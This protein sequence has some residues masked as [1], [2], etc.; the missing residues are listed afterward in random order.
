MIAQLAEACDG[1]IARLL[2]EEKLNSLNIHA[3]ISGLPPVNEVFVPIMQLA[4][5]LQKSKSQAKAKKVTPANIKKT[6]KAPVIDG[7]A[8]G[9]WSEA[10][11]YGISNQIYSPVSSPNDLSANY[12]VLWDKENLYLLVDVIDDELVND[13]E[14]FFYDDT[15]EVFID[16]DNSR[17]GGYGEND[18]TYNICWDGTSPSF[19]ERGQAYQNDDIKYALVTT[20][21]GYRL[22]MKFPWSALGAKPSPGAKIGLDVHVNDDDDGGERDTKFTWSDTQD[23]AF[24]NTRVFGTA[25]LAGLVGWWKFDESQGG[26]VSDSSGNNN[27][28]SLVGDPKWQPSG[29]ILGGALEFDGDGDYVKIENESN[30]D[31]AGQITVATWVNVASV[32]T[33]WTAIVTKGD[34]A[35]RLSTER[36]E[37][38]FH[39]AV[40]GN[41]LI[42]GLKT[43]S[44]NEWHHIAGV[45]DGSQMRMYVDGQLDASGSYNG[46]IEQNDYP[47]YIGENAEQT[48]RFWHGLIDDVR[49]YNYALPENEVKA[50]YKKDG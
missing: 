46:S 28:G 49:I 41:T 43:V 22:E 35:W 20:D 44:A 30:F 48:G 31:I 1:T 14:E 5:T 12:R 13:S 50:L 32:S 23:D 40:G 9:L 7:Q 36:A 24:Q 42:A 10:Q 11:K 45:C 17:D 18:Y 27:N 19:E 25:E 15:I 4:Q 2:T 39:F 34:S 16:A 8:E 38:R 37:R 21:N 6:N 29:G 33:E 26:N 3:S 47:V